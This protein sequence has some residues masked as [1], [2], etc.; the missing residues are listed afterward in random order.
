MEGISKSAKYVDDEVE[1]FIASSGKIEE[2]ISDNLRDKTEAFI[3]C[4]MKLE[5]QKTEILK[6]SGKLGMIN[7]IAPSG[8]YHV[9]RVHSARQPK[10]RPTC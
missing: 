3:E 6:I 1:L 9:P 5:S 8:V 4:G 10:N 7:D 2:A